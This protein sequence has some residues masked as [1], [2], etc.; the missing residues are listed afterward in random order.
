MRDSSW[1]SWAPNVCK[2]PGRAYILIVDVLAHLGGLVRLLWHVML[3]FHE[4]RLVH[5]D[6]IA[7]LV[8]QPVSQPSAAERYD[9][10]GSVEGSAKEP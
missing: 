7:S 6:A 8:P 10:E 5:W 2:R 4:I 3:P 1:V 9:A